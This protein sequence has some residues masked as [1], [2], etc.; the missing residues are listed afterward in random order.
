M[1]I[2]SKLIV[3]VE[4]LYGSAMSHKHQFILQKLF[5]MIVHIHDNFAFIVKLSGCA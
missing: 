4:S 5:I 2:M 1:T 3:R